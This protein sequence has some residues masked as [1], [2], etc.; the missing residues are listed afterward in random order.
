MLYIYIY[1]CRFYAPFHASMLTRLIPH[2]VR[3]Q[4]RTFHP[5]TSTTT[6]FSVILSTHRNKHAYRLWPTAL[7]FPLSKVTI[8][9]VITGRPISSA[10]HDARKSE[11]RKIKMYV[12]SSASHVGPR[13]RWSLFQQLS[14]RPSPAFYTVRPHYSS[15]LRRARLLMTAYCLKKK[16][17]A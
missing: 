4:P 2:T 12:K 8:E 10:S 11:E 3:C 7:P 17:P 1:I 13:R 14:A 9:D 6:F 5:C 16:S 15:S